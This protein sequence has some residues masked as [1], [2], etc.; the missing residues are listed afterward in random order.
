MDTLYQCCVSSPWIAIVNFNCI[1]VQ[2][3]TANPNLKQN[4]FLFLSTRISPSL[5]FHPSNYIVLSR[6]NDTGKRYTALSLCLFSCFSLS[7][8]I[9]EINSA[10]IKHRCIDGHSTG[11]EYDFVDCLAITTVNMVNGVWSE[12]IHVSL[13]CMICYAANSKYWS[14][15]FFWNCCMPMKVATFLAISLIIHSS[16]EIQ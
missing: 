14:M 11:L 15:L 7:Y 1:S 8:D 4:I 16:L 2:F 6:V 10:S 13:C 12:R 3:S 9:A 5:V